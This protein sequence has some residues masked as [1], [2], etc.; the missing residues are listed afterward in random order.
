MA[1]G[2]CPP[3]ARASTCNLVEGLIRYVEKEQ[4]VQKVCSKRPDNV[5][6][7]VSQSKDQ[8][9]VNNRV[10]RGRCADGCW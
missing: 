9:G 1:P 8:L 7:T 6:V 5:L 10:V 2:L 3:F 4:I